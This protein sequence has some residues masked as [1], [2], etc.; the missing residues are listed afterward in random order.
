[1]RLSLTTP[2]FGWLGEGEPYPDR[3]FPELTVRLDGKPVAP[4]AGFRAFAGARE[5][6]ELLSADHL[7][8]F[9]ITLTPPYLEPL[10]PSAPALDALAAAGAVSRRDGKTLAAWTVERTLTVSV[11]GGPA[12]VL[13]TS[14][15][16]RPAYDYLPAD[17][18]QAGPRLAPY[19]LNA[20]SLAEAL[21]QP[22]DPGALVGRESRCQQVS[23]G[24][25]RPWCRW[26]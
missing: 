25:R 20:T 11:P 21:G 6:T 15:Q 26:T 24:A 22:N 23:A 10:D 5:I 4:A 7:D 18:T 9:A 16:A 13:A 1:M 8:P 14:W 19:C 17:R 3:Q 12:V 2:R